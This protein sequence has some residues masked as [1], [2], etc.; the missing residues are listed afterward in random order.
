M[1]NK[2]KAP[3][4]TN[5]SVKRSELVCGGD[6]LHC[7]GSACSANHALIAE[8]VAEEAA[9]KA[10]E[11]KAAAAKKAAAEKAAQE[12]KAETPAAEAKKEADASQD[13]VGGMDR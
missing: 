2:F 4:A 8:K 5:G 9:R 11:K 7:Q 13:R 1:Q 12:Q 6:C 10:A 3:S